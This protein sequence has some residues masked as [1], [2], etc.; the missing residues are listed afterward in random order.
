M[1]FNF[2]VQLVLSILIFDSCKNSQNIGT[3]IVSLNSKAID[4]DKNFGSTIEFVVLNVPIINNFIKYNSQFDTFLIVKKTHLP[5]QFYLNESKTKREFIAYWKE[6]TQYKKDSLLFSSEKSFD[7]ETIFLLG[8]K[9]NDFIIIPDRNNNNLLEDDEPVIFK[10]YFL[11]AS[12]IPIDSLP[13]IEIKNLHCFYAGK[14]YSFNSKVILSP[15]FRDSSLRYKNGQ[16]TVNSLGLQLVTKKYYYGSFKIEKQKY[17]VVVLNQGSNLLSDWSFFSTFEKKGNRF[18]YLKNHDFSILKKIGDTIK[19]RNSYYV[20]D[21]FIP[22]SNELFLKKTYISNNALLDSLWVDFSFDEFISN[23]KVSMK[24]FQKDNQYLI[25]DFWGSWCEPCIK[26][27][28]E[29]KEAY[30]KLKTRNFEFLG[31]IYDSQDKVGVIK[32]IISENNITWPQIFIN[33]EE[34]LTVV[35]NYNVQ[36]FPTYFLIYQ[37][38]IIYRDFGIDGLKRLL[39]KIKLQ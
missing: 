27:I 38:K 1:R 24:Q 10:N 32:K 21:K 3:V 12:K 19:L 13:E 11:R 22:I 17:K 8:K 30:S 2:F 15:I 16:F 39:L 6:Y 31:V 14:E 4:D 7:A 5:Q 29:L 25:V 28:P 18:E 34:K 35:N 26:S 20:L 33:R 36:T 23:Q 37:G 9:N